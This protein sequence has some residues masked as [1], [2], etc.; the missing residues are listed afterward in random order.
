MGII[1]ERGI[2]KGKELENWRFVADSYKYSDI[3]FFA[4]KSW[5][6]MFEG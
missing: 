1:S 2:Q 5:K 6:E 4:G 3:K